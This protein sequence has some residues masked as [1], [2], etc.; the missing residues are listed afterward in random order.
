MLGFSKGHTPGTILPSAE[1]QEATIR[2][3]Y[4]AGGFEF[5]GTD[6]VKCSGTGSAGGDPI[7]LEALARCFSRHGRQHPLLIGPVSSLL[8]Y[9]VISSNPIPYKLTLVRFSFR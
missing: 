9:I 4:L 5:S 8:L 3:L 2:E 7:E 1:F 6:Y